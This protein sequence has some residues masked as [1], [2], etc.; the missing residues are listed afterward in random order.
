VVAH[1]VITGT[2]GFIAARVAELLL[3]AGHIVTGVD[4][5]NDAYDVRLKDWRL[6]RLLKKAGFRF[7]P[8][9]ISV[10]AALETFWRDLPRVDAVLN[11]AA[12]AGVR[13]SV[14]NPWVYFD[15]NVT[16]TLNLLD[17][18]R[19][20]NVPKFVL[21]SSSSVY[22]AGNDLPYRESANTDQPLSPYAASKKAAEVLCHTY[23]CLHGIDITVLRYF[24]VYGPAGRPDMSPFRFV[25]WISEGRPVMIFGDGRQR[26]DFT[27]VDDI[28]AGTIA[29]LR[30][31][32]FEIINLGSDR[33][34]AVM[35]II[36]LIESL[37]GRQAELRF[38]PAHSADV[39]ATWAD[40]RRAEE[41]LNWT[42]Q[43]SIEAGFDALYAWYRANQSWASQIS[44][45]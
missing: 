35:D 5:L 33:P 7:H 13:P 3:E 36:R 37:V 2:A 40:I 38:K 32:G 12:R 8:L 43:S 9:D 14:D 4:N 45:A 19:Q 16:G 20:A 28:A 30:P 22:G 24:T 41:L 21:A 23:H 11:L 18:C 10:R 39:L 15:T 42:P 6:Q 17:C 29:S 44:T 27:Y 25:Q 1:Y 26:R 34:V 31:L